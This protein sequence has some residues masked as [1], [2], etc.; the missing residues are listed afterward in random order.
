MVEKSFQAY[1]I[2]GP[3]QTRCSFSCNISWLFGRGTFT[4]RIIVHWENL[5]VNKREIPERNKRDD[6]DFW[7]YDEDLN[8]A[9][10]K[11]AGRQGD[12]KY[13]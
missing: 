12:S 6:Y 10:R 1:P 7:V 5:W 4:A 11:F 8:D 3:N 2:T 9:M 13:C